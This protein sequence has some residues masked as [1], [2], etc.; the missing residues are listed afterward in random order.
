M[1]NDRIEIKIDVQWD[2]ET[3]TSY[4]TVYG[5]GVNKWMT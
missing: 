1:G 3:L 4:R 5:P 2:N